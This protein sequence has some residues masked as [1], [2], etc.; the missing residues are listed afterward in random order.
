[1][2]KEDVLKDKSFAFALRCV[3]LFGYLREEKREY[4]LSKQLLRSGTSIGAN[5]KEGL[6]AQ[7]RADFLA[8][9]S[10]AKKEAAESEYWLELL[11]ASEIITSKEASSMLND[12]RELIKLLVSICKTTTSLR[13]NSQIASDLKPIS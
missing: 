8:K 5:I 2:K 12:C 4:V 3:R 7:S 11:E 6:Y 1:M 9:F 10:I 13:E